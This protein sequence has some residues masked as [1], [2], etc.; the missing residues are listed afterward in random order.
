MKGK[1]TLFSHLCCGVN[2]FALRSHLDEREPFDH[3]HHDNHS[4]QVYRS[5][6][7]SHIKNYTQRSAQRE[8]N[9]EAVTLPPLKNYSKWKPTWVAVM[10]MIPF[11]VT[12]APPSSRST[13]FGTL[14]SFEPW[15]RI[16]DSWMPSAE[17]GDHIVSVGGDTDLN[18]SADAGKEEG[19][20]SGIPFFQ[21]QIDEFPQTLG[22]RVEISRLRTNKLGCSICKSEYGKERGNTSTEPAV[23]DQELFTRWESARV[24]SKALIWPYIWRML[25]QDMTAWTACLLPDV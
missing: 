15:R 12:C 7:L 13:S 8:A 9:S 10:M 24:S 22:P 16:P 25:H 17:A 19:E 14:R 3:H 11:A 23:L 21:S 1:K 2:Y 5:N 18:Q 20:D 6:I 4:L